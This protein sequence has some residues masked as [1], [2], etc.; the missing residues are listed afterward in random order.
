MSNRK[1]KI[2]G[3]PESKE[4]VRNS[5]AAEPEKR[6][7]D[8][9][10][11]VRR[12]RRT[13]N[14]PNKGSDNTTETMKR[15]EAIIA[16][17][18]AQL[19]AGHL[20]E[21]RKTYRRWLCRY[22]DGAAAGKFK[23]LQGFMT[24]LSANEGLNPKTVRQALNA[25]VFFHKQVL[26]REI[27][28]LKVPRVNKNRNQPT[29]L[30]HEEVMELL[31]RMNG[32]PRLQAAM[33]YAT[34]SRIHALLSLR[35]KD[36]E[37][38]KGLV[39]FRFDKG[40]KSRTVRLADCLLPELRMHVERVIRLWETDHQAGRIAPHPE[41]SLMRK[42]GAKTFG[43]LPW[44]WLF[45][46]QVSHPTERWHATDRGL[47]KAVAKAAAA[48]RLMKRVTPHSLRHSHATALLTNGAN[49]REIQK[50]LGHTHVE[51]TEIYTHATGGGALRS[52]LD[53][54]SIIPFPAILPLTQTGTH[55]P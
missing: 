30:P 24:H 49:I 33:L 44:Y 34:G 46:S 23:D 36:L 43:T 2:A 18:T 5:I 4:Q 55:H 20:R 7:F 47:A 42:L 53:H 12:F 15:S 1:P 8:S 45:P 35:L 31:A 37:L 26:L 54:P 41:P 6:R 16:L 40:G 51:T 25:L 32:T 21:T 27:P 14:S 29:W 11:N 22:I 9:L 52:P 10:S 19:E 38:E 17:Q 3:S 28:E 50:Q 48:A 39:T 13:D